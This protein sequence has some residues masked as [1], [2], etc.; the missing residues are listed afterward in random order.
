MARGVSFFGST[1]GRKVVMALSGFVLFGFVLGHL[2]GNL[3]L[4]LGG[5]ICAS[6][7]QG[8]LPRRRHTWHSTMWPLRRDQWNASGRVALERVSISAIQMARC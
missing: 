8:L 2:A 3:Q 4:Y 7:G 1:I 6:N 5:V